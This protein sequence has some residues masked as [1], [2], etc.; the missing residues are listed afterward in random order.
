[1][2]IECEKKKSKRRLQHVNN[3]IEMLLLRSRICNLCWT[4]EE[5]EDE[6]KTTIHLKLELFDSFSNDASKNHL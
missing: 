2:T 5:N 1:M 3:G 4:T 6:E